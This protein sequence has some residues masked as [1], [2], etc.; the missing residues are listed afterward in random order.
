[1]LSIGMFGTETAR[2]GLP[3]FKRNKNCTSRVQI[4]KPTKHSVH[5]KISHKKNILFT[6]LE[7]IRSQALY[8][9]RKR[10]AQIW[11]LFPTVQDKLCAGKEEAGKMVGGKPRLERRC[12]TARDV[13][14]SIG[15]PISQVLEVDSLCA[16]LP[17]P[18]AS[19][20]R[21]V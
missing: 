14:P 11:V 20:V 5:K 21:P 3:K 18:L 1:M 12:V 10:G 17:S 16:P 4:V 15:R 6:K 8:E 13:P 7:I 2:L 9:F 19:M